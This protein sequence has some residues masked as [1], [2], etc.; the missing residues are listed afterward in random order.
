MLGT[1]HHSPEGEGPHTSPDTVPAAAIPS[2]PISSPLPFLEVQASLETAQRI[3]GLLSSTAVLTQTR[4]LSPQEK[5]TYISQS[6]FRKLQNGVSRLP[7][8]SRLEVEC[9]PIQ[10]KTIMYHP[11][12]VRLFVES[13]DSLS[14]RHVVR[15]LQS[16]DKGLSWISTGVGRLLDLS[17]SQGD[18]FDRALF[19]IKSIGLGVIAS[20][21]NTARDEI[22][23]VDAST[24]TPLGKDVVARM[25]LSIDSFAHI[26]EYISSLAKGE[27]CCSK[28]ALSELLS[29]G[30][31]HILE[32]Q[33]ALCSGDDLKAQK[34]VDREIDDRKRAS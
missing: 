6:W 23:S 14:A 10:M 22:I 16:F 25:L 28:E 8:A 29:E 1:Q 20:N 7:M 32:I 3:L 27:E 12:L 9:E 15:A 4:A 19:A 34:P 5:A 30:V 31:R 13:E 33:A 11:Q 24:F 2:Q 17:E 26:P 18:D 21:L